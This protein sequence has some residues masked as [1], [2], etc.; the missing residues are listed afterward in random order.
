M[1]SFKDMMPE[2]DMGFSD[3]VGRAALQERSSK[4]GAMITPTD[5]VQVT[6]DMN[7]FFASQGVPSAVLDSSSMMQDPMMTPEDDYDA[8]EADMFSQIM[9]ERMSKENFDSE[10][11]QANTVI[12]NQNE[13][14][15]MKKSGV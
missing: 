14:D 4:D 9:Q 5:I 7:P 8:D 6:P 13:A 3:D 2:P 15:M 1:S 12:D 11:A 10:A